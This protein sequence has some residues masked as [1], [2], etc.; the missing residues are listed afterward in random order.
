MSDNQPDSSEEQKRDP[1]EPFMIDGDKA[2]IA[3]Q[4]P[5]GTWTKIDSFNNFF[6][7]QLRISDSPFRME[8]RSDAKI[9]GDE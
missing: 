7:R 3:K 9:D 5:D 6:R 1:S 2:A 4:N 8:P